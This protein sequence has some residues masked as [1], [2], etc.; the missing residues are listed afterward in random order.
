MALSFNF[1]PRHCA[2][3]DCLHAIFAGV[4]ESRTTAKRFMSGVQYS[5]VKRLLETYTHTKYDDEGDKCFM[6]GIGR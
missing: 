6:S 3:E 2:I 1:L 4:E 5:N